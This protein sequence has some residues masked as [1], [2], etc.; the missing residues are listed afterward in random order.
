MALLTDDMDLN[1][2]W[3]RG[4]WGGN[5]DIYIEIIHKDDKTGLKTSKGVRIATSGGLATTE[6]KIAA[7]RFVDA[8]E[9]AGLNGFPD[10]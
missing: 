10:E 5:G 3:I 1:T 9:D 4:F 2:T 7:A 8:L 6:V